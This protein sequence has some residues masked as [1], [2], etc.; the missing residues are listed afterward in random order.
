MELDELK[1]ELKL[2]D[3]PQ[4]RAIKFHAQCQVNYVGY[5]SQRIK[6][7]KGFSAQFIWF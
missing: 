1:F 2:S 4:S 3:I 6:D 5:C 7:L